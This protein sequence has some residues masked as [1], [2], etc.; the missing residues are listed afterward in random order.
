MSGGQPRRILLACDFFLRYTAMLAAGLE[1]AGGEVALLSRDHDMEFGDRPGAAEEFV[2]GAL[3]PKGKRCTVPGRVRSPRGVAA[4]F[5]ARAAVGRFSPDFVHLQ[6]GIGNDPRLILAS[7]ARRR[8]F[9]LTVHDPVR[10]PG[11]AVARSAQIGNRL[12]IRSAGLIFVHAEALRDE[13]REA[14][15]PRAPIVVVPHGVEPGSSAPLPERPSVLFFGRIGHYK[16]LDVL[17]DAMDEVWERL[18]DARL[19]IA[20]AGQLEDHPALSDARVTVR[21]EH[22]PDGEV[23]PLFAATTCV[24]LPYRQASQSGVGSLAKRYGRPLVVSSVGGLPELVADG[25]GLAVPAEQPAALA[26]ALTSVL[27][28]RDLAERLGEAGNRSAERGSD[29]T[30]VGAATL[31]AYEQHLASASP[32]MER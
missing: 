17:L 32:G 14:V 27:A 23:E 4:A 29:W 13:L 19:T 31:R 11:E 6:T 22:I 3:S 8:R 10:H 24:A 25:S 12:L 5:R 2:S 20:G 1:R 30:A 7:R 28:D 18:P 26:T 16:G 21:A 15:R 9:A